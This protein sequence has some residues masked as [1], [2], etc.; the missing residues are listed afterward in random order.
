[1]SNPFDPKANIL[2]GT[3]YLSRL[4]ER[5]RGTLVLALAAYNAGPEKVER[6]KGIPP[7]PE[8]RRYVRSV[9]KQWQEYRSD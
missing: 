7:Y 9:L 2:G 1:V 5:F 3:K 8:T 4:I 6:Y